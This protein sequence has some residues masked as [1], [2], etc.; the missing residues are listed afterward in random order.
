MEQAE[1]GGWRG[2]HPTLPHIFS[3]PFFGVK[4][5]ENSFSCNCVCFD[6]V[7]A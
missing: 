7:D 3:Y 5:L 4:A 1:R 6:S 2:L